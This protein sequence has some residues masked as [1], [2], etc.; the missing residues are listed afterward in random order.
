[1]IKVLEAL[2][3]RSRWSLVLAGLAV[4]VL[5]GI[6]DYLTG[7]EM[8][9][10]VFYLLEVGLAAWFVGKGFGIVMS[11]LS[12]LV[13]IG[14]D[15]PAGAHYSR[16]FVPIWNAAILVIVYSTVVWILTSLRR[17]QT[18]LESKVQQRTVALTQEMAE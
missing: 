6:I 18:E 11:I 4:L 13:W 12:V 9:F 3:R 14:G 7:F 10:S 2:E 15:V 17:L 16:P 8:L 1:M 5:I